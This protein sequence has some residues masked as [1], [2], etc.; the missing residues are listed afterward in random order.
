MCGQ[1]H[2]DS[3]LKR[4]GTARLDSPKDTHGLDRPRDI[5]GLDSPKDMRGLDSL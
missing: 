3:S 1:R 4:P 5:R 2:Q